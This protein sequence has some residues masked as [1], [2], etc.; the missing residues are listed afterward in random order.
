MKEPSSEFG[1]QIGSKH[2]QFGVQIREA[3]I[4]LRPET[5]RMQFIESAQPQ[6]FRWWFFRYIYI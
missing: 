6:K 4:L 5:M 3:L 1:H 2:V